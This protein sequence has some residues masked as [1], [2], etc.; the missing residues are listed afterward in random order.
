ML[1]YGLKKR[2]KG[3]GTSKRKNAIHRKMKKEQMFV[4]TFPGPGRNSGW[5]KEKV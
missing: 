5:A 3:S 1:H 4:N 2:G